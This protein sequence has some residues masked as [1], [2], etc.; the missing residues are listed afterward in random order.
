VIGPSTMAWSNATTRAFCLESSQ[1]PI[2]SHTLA[3]IAHIPASAFGYV[4]GG[5]QIYVRTRAFVN[6]FFVLPIYEAT[7]CALLL[8]SERF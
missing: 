1:Q 6:Y 8:Q 4:L 7:L 3:K 2:Q 5:Q